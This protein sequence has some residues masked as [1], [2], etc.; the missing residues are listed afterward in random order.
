MA[1]QD[2]RIELTDAVG[3]RAL[4]YVDAVGRQ[5]YR[6]NVEELDAYIEE[7]FAHPGRHGTPARRVFPWTLTAQ[8]FFEQMTV[9]VEGQPGRPGESVTAWLTRLRW[10]RRDGEKVQMTAL[11]S[12]VLAHLDEESFEADIPVALVLDQ[13]DPLATARVMGRIGEL[14][15]C[16]LVD[17]Y[18]TFERLPDLMRATQVERVLTS[19]RDPKKVEVL[20]LALAG[21]GS[22][23]SPDIRTRDVFH[24]RFVIPDTG[25][26][27]LLGTSLT[28]VGKRLALMVE[29]K[30]ETVSG[31]IRTRFE[32]EWAQAEPLRDEERAEA[33]DETVSEEQEG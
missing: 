14:G 7:P 31:A 23:A 9:E 2:R 16:A 13:D 32:E 17:P 28:G 4:K 3:H 11:G 15:A 10:L 27:W 30:D 33:P 1:G 8:R 29:V 22:D 6:L 26:I 20:R 19:A 18:F 25:P 24:D 5:G 12:A 21:F